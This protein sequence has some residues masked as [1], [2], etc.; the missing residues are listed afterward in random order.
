MTAQTTEGRS[1]G[2]AE[3]RTRPP[4]A[5]WPVWTL[6]IFTGAKSFR[7]N[8]ILGSRAMNR[9]GLH[10]ARKVLAHAATS[11]RRALLSP[12]VPAAA[13]R[14]FRR[15]GYVAI[16]DF[17]APAQFEALRAEADALLAASG[18]RLQEGDT[19]TELALVDEE[20]LGRAPALASFF[21]D[22][23]FLDLT[24]YIGARLKLPRCYVQSIRRDFTANAPDPQKDAHSD[25]FFPTLKGWLFLDDVDEDQ[26]PFHYSPG[27]HRLTWPRLAWEY[28]QSLGARSAEDPHTAAGSL[29]AARPDLEEMGLPEPKPVLVKANTLVLADTGGF[30]RRGEA[31]VGRPRR[32]IY[33][34]MRSNPYNPILGFRSRAWRR[35]ELAV[36]KASRNRAPSEE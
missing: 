20:A 26:G 35:M 34:W 32:A 21:S 4:L 6:E 17:M 27:S 19:I 18:R 7:S 29:R 33:V 22:Q 14:T 9:M 28:R 12:L 10:V 1:A 8:P 23:R 15:H 30:H 16:E 5:R 2:P 3:V 31:K 11:V 36:T 25:T 24:S 13:R